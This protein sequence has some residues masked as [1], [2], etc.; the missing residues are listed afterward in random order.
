MCIC[1]SFSRA[2][3]PLQQ[4][5]AAGNVLQGSECSVHFLFLLLKIQKFSPNNERMLSSL[6]AVLGLHLVGF[7]NSIPQI[8]CIP[9]NRS[10]RWIDVARFRL[11]YCG[12]LIILTSVFCFDG[13]NALKVGRFLEKVELD[14][15]FNA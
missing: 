4:G 3:P 14:N 5:E 8:C 15:T 9:W 10:L 13:K 6:S 12:C 1:L 2:F 11:Q 7:N